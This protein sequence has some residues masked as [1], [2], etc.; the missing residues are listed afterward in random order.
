MLLPEPTIFRKMVGALQYV[1]PTRPNI[2][3]VD[4]L[5]SQYMHK[6]RAPHLQL[7]K[8]ILWYLPRTVHHGILL[9]WRS[10]L[11]LSVY[12]DAD[13]VVSSDARRSTT[14]L[15]ILL[16]S[17][18]IWWHA[19]KQTIDARSSTEVEYRAVAHYIEK[20]I[21]IPHL[22]GELDLPLYVSPTVFCVNIS[23]ILVT[24]P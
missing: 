12:F 17:N 13:R 6:P 1:T 22:L 16:G 18:L 14:D 23:Y 2:S 5:V 10:T 21:C 4:N 3:F 15:C 24:Q 7:V 11:K 19:M 9:R 8:R 20:L